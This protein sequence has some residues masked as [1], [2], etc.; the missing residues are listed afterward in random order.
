MELDTSL[1][2]G[3]ALGARLIGRSCGIG[4]KSSIFG[5]WPRRKSGTRSAGA[6]WQERDSSIRICGVGIVIINLS[7]YPVRIAGLAFLLDGTTFF[8]F[9]RSSHEESWLPEIPSHARMVVG[10]TEPEWN[11]ILFALGNRGKATALKFVAVAVTETGCRFAS[12]RL[13]VR[14]MK[15]SVSIQ[16]WAIKVFTR[17]PK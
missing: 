13:S 6:L 14:I 7:L 15:P 3:T 11:Q 10:T 1:S 12:N 16:R 5:F 4:K 9:Y 17:K 8:Q 2:S